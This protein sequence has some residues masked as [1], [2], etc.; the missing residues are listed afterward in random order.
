[1]VKKKKQSFL[2]EEPLWYKRAIIYQCHVRAF[3]DS[4][5]DGVGDFKGLT[6]KLNYLQDLGITTL[7]LL[8]FY[9]SPLRDDGYDIADYYSIH[10]SYG[11]LADFRDLLREAHKRGIRVVTELVINHTSDQH[12]WFQKSRRAK[13]GTKWHNYYVWNDS[14]KK[15]K[16]ARIIFK[17]FE[18]SN[19]SWDPVANSYY[20]HRFY[21]HQPDLNFENPEV[22]KEL[23]KI[24]DFWL[25]MG[26]DGLRLDA[27]PYLYAEEG[28]NCENLPQTHA[29]LKKL[30]KHVDDNFEDRMLIAEANQWPEDAVAYFGE[31]EG[32]E[33]HVAFHFPV[34]PRLF[35]GLRMED[36]VPIV[37][38]M[39]Q[40]PDIPA[41]SQ[42]AIFLRNHDELTLEMVTDEER[43]YMYRMYA[44]DP[45]A[46]I[47]LGIRRRL[48]PLLGN[49]RK[50]IELLNALLF[51]FPGTPVVYYG[52]E[53]G[54]GDNVYLGDRNGV[55]TPMQWSSDKNA[56]FSRANP[57]GLFLPVI[58]D[59][60]YHFE[61]VNVE[62]QRSNLHSLLWWMTRLIAARKRWKAFGHGSMEFLH[63]ENRKVLA[64]IRRY[65][66]EI[67]LVVANLS[68][69]VQPVELD[70]SEF[71]HSEPIEIFGRITFPG[72]TE[73]PYFLTLG[74]HGFYWFALS[75]ITSAKEANRFE[76]LTGGSPIAVKDRWESVL[77]DIRPKKKLEAVLLDY[78][79]ERRWFASKSK[80]I[81]N[82]SITESIPVPCKSETVFLTMLKIDYVQDD[83]ETYLLPLA[84]MQE[85]NDLFA[86]SPHLAVA[87]IEVS[88]KNKSGILYDATANPA[89]GT[90]LLNAAAR[91]R[92]LSS[93]TFDLVAT[94][95]PML[96][97]IQRS[98]ESL[99]PS[100]SRAEQSNTSV[101]F[102]DQ[103]IMK[104]FRRLEEGLNPE[105]EMNRFL[106]ERNFPHVPALAGTLELETKQK[107]NISLGIITRF[108]P[109]SQDAGEYAVE[110]LTSFLEH[111]QAME[112]EA[113]LEPHHAGGLMNAYKQE[114]P[115]EVAN[116]LDVF[117]EST[118]KL[119]ELTAELHVTLA[120]DPDNK[121]FA[122][123]PFTPFYQRS[124]YQSMRNLCVQTMQLLKRHLK[125]FPEEM[126]EDA[127]K[128]LDLNDEI[129][130]RFR[131]VADNPVS[132]KRI[133]CHGDYHLGQV[134]YTGREFVILDFEGEPARS[135]S[136]RRIKRPPLRD[137]GGMIRSFHYAAYAGYTRYVEMDNISLD[138]ISQIEPWVQSWYEWVS[139]TF[140][141]A[142]VEGVHGHDLIPETEE[143][144]DTLL[145]ASLLE[146][147]LYELRY[148]LNNRP[149]WVKIPLHG[150]LQ[151]LQNH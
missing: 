143:G 12:P 6:T 42:W 50:R 47:N 51:S 11:T 64:Y 57:Q 5:S 110:S 13:P 60:E 22:H 140:L 141:R 139:A 29:F 145:H 92:V 7:W 4:N 119:G 133:R 146:K 89:L 19:W 147:A 38:I 101:I 151:L 66:D 124:L 114:V 127:Q 79:K 82:I 61:T 135:L 126:K 21:S 3:L 116:L 33:C 68:R 34:M 87:A 31:G 16:E 46:R 25:G 103:L 78:V 28:T 75:P 71:E 129:L 99:E 91:K 95:T 136:E 44:N 85:K 32:D 55:R 20:W 98:A 120:S 105:L 26:V 74:P 94:G 69:F 65:E 81:K 14:D 40:T 62:A 88:N 118:R 86:D 112:T 104:L 90:A 10:P 15:Y 36:R 73:E 76:A 138:R 131:K 58:V 63:P 96:R 102:G 54:M 100:L 109:N 132:G 84:F 117:L 67:I 24:L 113:P 111:I 122:P 121:D 70:L 39:E 137:V 8:P 115:P 149:H 18:T 43:D 2:E 83:P 93:D 35:M 1:M 123:E 30:R 49:D 23:F 17:D 108:I 80:D 148:E 72:I 59:P 27:I 128:V 37:D 9:P 77:S 56:G 97:R 106:T 107:K 52:D 125:T 142:Y 48:A 134:L 53:I 144:F 45:K 150:I 41:T 130:K